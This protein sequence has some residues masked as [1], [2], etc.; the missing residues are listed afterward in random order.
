MRESDSVELEMISARPEFQALT[1]AEVFEGLRD[2]EC[3]IACEVTR[4]IV[5]F[6]VKFRSLVR[7]HGSVPPHAMHVAAR[8]AIEKVAVV[9]LVEYVRVETAARTLH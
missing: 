3:P 1:E 6:F 4:L 9:I 8:C 7:V 2:D 5:N